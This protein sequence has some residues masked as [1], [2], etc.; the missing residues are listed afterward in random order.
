MQ[1]SKNKAVFAMLTKSAF[2]FEPCNKVQTL[3]AGRLISSHSAVIVAVAVVV[4][5]PMLWRGW[6]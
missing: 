5:S 2:S 1:I 4:F 3:L 6:Q